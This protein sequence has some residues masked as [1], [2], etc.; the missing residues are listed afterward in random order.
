M[1]QVGVHDHHR[2]AASVVEPGGDR[3]LLAEVAAERDRSDA[4]VAGIA[5]SD[6]RKRPVLAAVVHEQDLPGRRDALQHGA[7]PL[8]ERADI[9]TLVVDG[10]DDAE[11]DLGGAH[12]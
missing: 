9:G 2:P 7:E 12:P 4:R 1:L 6:G 5:R 3:D 10:D 8:A 11:V